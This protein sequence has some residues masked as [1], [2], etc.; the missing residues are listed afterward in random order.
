M[1]TVYICPDQFKKDNWTIA[2][3]DDVCAFLQWQF[4]KFPEFARIYHKSV[5]PQNDV[6]PIDERGLRNLQALD[7]EFYVVICSGV[8]GWDDIILY[9]VMAITAAFSIYTY[10]TMPKPQNQ[11][12][13]SPNN[14]LASR[15]NQIRL[16]GRIT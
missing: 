8:M 13:Q 15:Q 3:V 5:A 10:M 6:T 16:N 12:P 14:D 4:E 7:G 1:K 11:S 2:E 9:A